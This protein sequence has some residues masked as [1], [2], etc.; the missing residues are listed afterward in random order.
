MVPSFRQCLGSDTG[1]VHPVRHAH[2]GR[3]QW[4]A[5]RRGLMRSDMRQNII[6]QAQRDE[7]RKQGFISVK[8]PRVHV[9]AA[10]CFW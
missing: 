3:T 6:L 2:A 7:D 5:G 9:H 4:H 1:G 10:A 8:L